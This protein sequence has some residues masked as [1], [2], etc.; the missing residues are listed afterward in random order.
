MVRE[1]WC[2]LWDPVS[3]IL[4]VHWLDVPEGIEYKI[5]ITVQ[6]CQTAG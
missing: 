5:G 6:Y 3:V 1:G 2:Y 4:M